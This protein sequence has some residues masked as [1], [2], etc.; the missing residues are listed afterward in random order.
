MTVHDP[1]LEGIRHTPEFDRIA[2]RA[3]KVWQSFDA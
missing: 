2:G 1:L 3:E